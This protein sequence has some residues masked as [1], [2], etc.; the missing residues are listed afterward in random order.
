M[1]NSQDI[2]HSKKELD[3]IMNF[4]EQVEEVEQEIVKKLLIE[5]EKIHEMCS[6]RDNDGH[7]YQIPVTKK[8]EWKTFCDIPSDDES[9]WEVPEWAERIDGMPVDSIKKKV[10]DLLTSIQKTL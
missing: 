3:H 10:I 9:S 4:T 8:K 5:V 2:L 7:R 6:A 1:K